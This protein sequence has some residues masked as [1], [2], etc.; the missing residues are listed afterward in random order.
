MV[1]SHA[2]ILDD[3]THG[4]QKNTL[5]PMEA[6]DHNNLITIEDVIVEPPAEGVVVD[7]AE[8]FDTPADIELEIGCGKGGFLLE[9]AKACPE[10]NLIG[11]EWANKYY[12]YI[13]DRMARW[14]IPNVR[15]MRTDADFFVKHQLAPG[16]LSALHVYHPDPWP[17]KRHHRRRLIQPDFVDAAVRALRPGARWAVQTDHADYYEQI[18]PILL[19]HP[20]LRQT[21]FDDPDYGVKNDSTATNFEVKYVREGR[22]IYRLAV[23]KCSTDKV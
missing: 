8:W 13:A 20:D 7:P 9:R 5:T 23:V 12:K 15:V 14:G 2:A 17:K 18:E 21:P 4:R 19:D 1:L 11:I 3:R 6:V 16:C 22:A 10:K